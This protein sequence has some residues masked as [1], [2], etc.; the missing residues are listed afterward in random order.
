M[1]GAR[2]FLGQFKPVHK[3][4]LNIC[5]T[6]IVV[7]AQTDVD[8]QKHRSI[9]KDERIK[10]VSNEYNTIQRVILHGQSV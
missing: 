4:F 10:R 6:V 9:V 2:N 1:C 7:V 3:N 5:M 8:H